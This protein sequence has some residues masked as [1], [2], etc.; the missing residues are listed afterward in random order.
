[1]THNNAVEPNRESYARAQ[2]SAM[3]GNGRDLIY[4]PE[5][6]TFE[7]WPS[8]IDGHYGIVLFRNAH[9]TGYDTDEF[10]NEQ[11][12][13]DFFMSHAY[14]EGW[15]EVLRQIDEIQQ[16]AEKLEMVSVGEAAAIRNVAKITVNKW[17]SDQGLPA[18]KIGN[19]YVIRFSDLMA[20]EP[21]S[22]GRPS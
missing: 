18:R 2:A 21:A 5:D 1:M 22:V 13:V 14:N 12:C 20:F 15:V 16:E 17:I 8:G 10:A 9:D 7:D 11:D 6:G 4:Y 3:F 19:Q